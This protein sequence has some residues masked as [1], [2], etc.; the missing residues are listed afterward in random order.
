M[1]EGGVVFRGVKSWRR[2]QPPKRKKFLI[3]YMLMIMLSG[4]L[5]MHVLSVFNVL[6]MLIARVLGEWV[7]TPYA[8]DDI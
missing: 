3:K 7:I 1:F 4:L 5:K 2:V 8:Y 6:K